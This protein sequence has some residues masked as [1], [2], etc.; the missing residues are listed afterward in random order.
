MQWFDKVRQGSVQ[1]SEWNWTGSLDFG[2]LQACREDLEFYDEY[3]TQTDT[4][5]D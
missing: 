5:T 3:L 1:Y 2:T 4:I